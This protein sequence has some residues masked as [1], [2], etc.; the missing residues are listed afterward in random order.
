MGQCAPTR[1]R[2][3]HEVDRRQLVEPVGARRPR[4]GDVAIGVV[5]R[6]AN[7][8]DRHGT[9]VPCDLHRMLLVRVPI[10]GR[11]PAVGGTSESRTARRRTTNPARA[12][13]RESWRNDQT[14]HASHS[15]AATTPR[16]AATPRRTR[17][18]PKAHNQAAAMRNQP[19]AAR[20]PAQDRRNNRR[21]RA[22]FV[23]RSRLTAAPASSRRSAPARPSASCRSPS[24]APTA[25]R[26]A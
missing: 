6:T 8:V 17:G 26:R 18:A 15:T 10:H 7:V 20:D 25:S 14:A 5:R 9:L 12:R 23:A 3:H 2:R 11:R 21:A 19:D 1:K 16:I 24:T 13:R 4:K 22:A